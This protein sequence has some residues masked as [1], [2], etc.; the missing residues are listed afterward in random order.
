MHIC[1]CLSCLLHLCSFYQ[2]IK[3]FLI[4]HDVWDLKFYL[5][6][7]KFVTQAL[8]D[9]HLPKESSL[10]CFIPCH[11]WNFHNLHKCSR[12]LPI[13]VIRESQKMRDIF[14]QNGASQ[15]CWTSPLRNSSLLIQV[16]F[17]FRFI[18]HFLSCFCRFLTECP[19]LL[20]NSEKIYSFL[21][22]HQSL[23]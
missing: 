7:F 2:F 14:T 10:H 15:L 19:H 21:K 22:S 18:Q 9:L 16:S 13:E 8:V 1:L 23:L 6:K 3:Y 11:I 4:P 5:S 12:F 20:V 17:T